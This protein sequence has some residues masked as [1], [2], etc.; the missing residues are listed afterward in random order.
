MNS[1]GGARQFRLGGGRKNNC[2]EHLIASDCSLHSLNGRAGG[3]LDAGELERLV[4][5][6]V[7]RSNAVGFEACQDQV[8]GFTRRKSGEQQIFQ[9]RNPKVGFPHDLRGHA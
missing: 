9:A 1:E 7:R 5:A 2:L 4:R 6:A 3:C 8:I